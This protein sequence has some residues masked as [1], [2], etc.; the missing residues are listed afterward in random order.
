M[1][2]RSGGSTTTSYGRTA[3]AGGCRQRSSRRSIDR[4]PAAPSRRRCKPRSNLL[5]PSGFLKSTGTG[6]GGR[7]RELSVQGHSSQGRNRHGRFSTFAKAARAQ[8]SGHDRTLRAFPQRRH[9]KAASLGRFRPTQSSGNTLPMWPGM[10]SVMAIAKRRAISITT[11]TS[12]KSGR[13]AG[14]IRMR[15]V[16]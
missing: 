13:S 7:S 15:L 5:Q 14:A 9:R 2:L 6:S 12:A 8:E 16:R 1:R 4:Q 11:I 10:N 3:A